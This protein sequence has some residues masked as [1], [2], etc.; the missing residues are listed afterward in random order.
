MKKKKK[1]KVFA[2]PLENALRRI[3][4]D[5]FLTVRLIW[6]IPNLNNGGSLNNCTLSSVNKQGISSHI[7]VQPSILCSIS[8]EFAVTGVDFPGLL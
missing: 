6:N 5:T 7:K 3:S 4:K 2:V 8:D 1:L